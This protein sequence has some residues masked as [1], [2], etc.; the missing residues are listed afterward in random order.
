MGYSKKIK[1]FELIGAGG[2]VNYD[3]Y[4]RVYV[5][6]SKK[7]IKDRSTFGNITFYYP[8]ECTLYSEGEINLGEHS[9]LL[10]LEA[11]GFLLSD[12]WI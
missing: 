12:I 4:D 9:G 10:N 11:F 6:A 3:E 7:K 8:Y 1:D 5:I 2:Y